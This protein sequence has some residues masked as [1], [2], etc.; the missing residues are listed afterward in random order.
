MI[1]IEKAKKEFDKYAKKYDLEEENLNMKY[2]HTY[3]VMD[4]CEEIAKKLNLNEEEIKLAALI[5][6]LHDIARFEQ[7]TKYKTFSDLNS[8]DHGDF[9]VEILENENFI[10][11]FIEENKYDNI[12]K[13]AIKN[14]NKYKI[15]DGLTEEEL[16]YSKIIKDA[17]K[18]DIFYVVLEVFSKNDKQKQEIE[19]GAI[20]DDVMEQIKQER[21][22]QRKTNATS[23]DGY[24][25][26]L[27]F[28]FDFYFSYSYKI[29][30]KEDY[31]N[32]LIDKYDFKNE[33][34][35]IKMEQIRTKLNK[36]IQEN[37]G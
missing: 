37:K 33:D 4:L 30:E 25:V 15:E 17:D 27:S 3:R 21:L 13:K 24:L 19:N 11:D 16:L 35:K 10:R 2:Y 29:I 36:Y 5:G 28:V 31:I 8:I 1:D 12:I 26:N 32:K 7:Y 14:H 23:M 6:L 22:V 34:T 9:G 18:L 20:S